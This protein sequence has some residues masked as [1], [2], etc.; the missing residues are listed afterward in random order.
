MDTLVRL[1]TTMLFVVFAWTGNVRILMSYFFATCA[2]WLCIRIVTA[3][4][5]SPKGNGCVEGGH[6]F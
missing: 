2:I 1:W 6:F 3:F 4:L 5:T